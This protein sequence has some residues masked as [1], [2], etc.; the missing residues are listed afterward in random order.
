MKGIQNIA[1]LGQLAIQRSYSKNEDIKLLEENGYTKDNAKS[2]M[3]GY[4]DGLSYILSMINPDIDFEG[5]INKMIDN[6]IIDLSTIK[7]GTILASKKVADITNNLSLVLSCTKTNEG[8]YITT[9]PIVTDIGNYRWER[10]HDIVIEGLPDIYSKELA[11]D[12]G[13]MV[14]INMKHQNLRKITAMFSIIHEISENQVT[15]IITAFEA[16]DKEMG[17][18]YD[19][20]IQKHN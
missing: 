12:L 4:V 13:T 17:E 5:F 1:R 11:I 20:A 16:Y 14:P 6:E 9:T 2:Y 10:K 3:D 19:A 15:E 7:P 18:L 8:V